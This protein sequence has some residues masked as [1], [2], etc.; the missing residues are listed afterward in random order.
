MAV[1]A[2][3]AAQR[4]IAMAQLFWKRPAEAAALE[5]YRQLA[6]RTVAPAG[7]VA[8]VVSTPRAA[9]AAAAERAAEEP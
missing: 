2:E 1:S 4:L 8:V 6:S 9:L 3:A 7:T 5:V